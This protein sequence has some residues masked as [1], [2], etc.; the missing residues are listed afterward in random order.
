MSETGKNVGFQWWNDEYSY[1][2]INDE[3]EGF[4]SSLLI[5]VGPEA[6][7]NGQWA[8]VAHFE[9]PAETAIS[10]LS[11]LMTFDEHTQIHIVTKNEE[12]A[13]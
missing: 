13:A 2:L 11:S 1:L 8:V 5:A 7:F 3:K 9:V 12:P 10:F 6:D 4:P